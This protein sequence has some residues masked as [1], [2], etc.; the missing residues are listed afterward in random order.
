MSTQPIGMAIA[1]LGGMTQRFWILPVLL[2][3]AVA[4]ACGGSSP[5]S[6]AGNAVGASIS[7]TVQ[8]GGSTALTASGIGHAI[9]GLTVTVTGTSISSGVDAAGRFTLKG[10][11]AGDVQLQ[12]SGPVTGSLQVN[13]V[14]PAETITLVIG[15][16]TGTITLESQTR[17]SA[18]EEQLEGRI[19]S[20]PPTM[21]AGSLKVAGRTVTTDGSTQI[22]Q[23]GA[24]R[25]FSD[26]QVGY[27]VHVKGHT[28]GSNLL[29]TSIEIQNTNTAIPVNVNG[30]IDTLT[31]SASDFSFK[32]GSR[33]IRGDANTQFFGDGSNSDSFDDLENG[34][35]V[36]VKGQQRDGFIY[37]ERIHINNGDDD[38]DDDD[39]DS[40][41]S[42][43][44]TLTAISG[45]APSLT[46][47]VGGTTVRTSSST[48]VKRKGDVQTLAALKTGMDLHVVGT[49]QSDGSLEARKIEI[50][51][52]ATG[53]EFEIE[54]SAG[55][56]SGSC[57]TVTFG[58][59]GYTIRTNASTQFEGITC[60]ALKS[61]TKVN[62]QG[63]SQADNSVLATR[64]KPK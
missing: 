36:E 7:G 2:L 30:V 26:L 23:G 63:V 1:E 42:I 11:P 16:S 13:A 58:V 22:R 48:E 14:Q 32:I 10:V 59:N 45:T 60:A 52:D 21:A 28:S 53:G 46:L 62:V 20:L 6:P 57:P 4:T 18:G 5:T 39:Q 34:A 47:T 8:G 56:V 15:V 19:E 3:T 38:N 55:G 50:R 43:H 49:R 40:S 27:R 29:A 51:D 33:F 9:A 17:S 35:R 44:G 41:A 54:G 12:F 37:A 64:V 24:T 61:G 25:T 31:G